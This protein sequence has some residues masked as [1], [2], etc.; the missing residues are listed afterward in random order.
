MIAGSIIAVAGLLY[1]IFEDFVLSDFS[2]VRTESRQPKR[3]G[4]ERLLVGTQARHPET[5]PRNAE[6][7]RP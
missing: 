4:P 1:L 6:L 2:V 3:L 7:I 5:E